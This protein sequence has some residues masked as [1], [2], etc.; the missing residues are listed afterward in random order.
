MA[1]EHRVFRYDVAELEAWKAGRYALL[2]RSKASEFLKRILIAKA[3]RRRAGRGAR[4]QQGDRRFFGEAFVAAHAAFSHQAGWYGSFKWLSAATWSPRILEGPTGYAQDLKRALGA[5]VENL[6]EV[7][8]Q[9]EVL[10]PRLRGRYAVP[11]DLWLLTGE[12][13]R[14]IEV[15]LPG[16]RL[17]DTQLAGLALIATSLRADRPV[18]VEVIRLVDDSNRRDGWTESEQGTFE[19]LCSLLNGSASGRRERSGW[20]WREGKV[21]VALEH[22]EL[23]YGDSSTG[24]YA[25][26]IPVAIVGRP[27]GRAFP[28]QWLGPVAVEIV[29]AVRRELDFYLVE[30]PVSH[31]PTGG[32]WEYAVHHCGT[33][34]NVYS[35]VHWSHVRPRSVGIAGSRNGSA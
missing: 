17:R 29:A 16:D 19:S 9:Q 2:E 15:K 10:R 7:R 32:P 34:A 20:S 26:W 35:S 21:D 4:G 31:P 28:V 27:L 30:H 18:S 11:P 3:E 6:E 22:L 8:R 25:D 13:H 33:N 5:Y 12:T 24:G 23:R 14:F 1:L